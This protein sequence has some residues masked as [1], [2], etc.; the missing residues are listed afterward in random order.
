MGTMAACT[1]LSATQGHLL[2]GESYCLGAELCRTTT[3]FANHVCQKT[4]DFVVQEKRVMLP[5]SCSSQLANSTPFGLPAG[6][7]SNIPKD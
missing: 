2:S 4:C 6:T 1:L 5:G 7:R 3:G